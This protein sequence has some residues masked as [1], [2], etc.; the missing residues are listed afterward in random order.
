MKIIFAHKGTDI[1]LRARNHTSVGITSIIECGNAFTVRHNIEYKHE[2]KFNDMIDEDGVCPMPIMPNGGDDGECIYRL[3]PQK[4]GV[5]MVL[6]KH[7]FRGEVEDTE[8]FL[9]IVFWV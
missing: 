2:N 5:H 3:I 7:L 1:I 4:R 8:R 6:L 9:I